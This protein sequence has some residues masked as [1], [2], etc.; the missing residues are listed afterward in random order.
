MNK[1]D[2]SNEKLTKIYVWTN[3]LFQL[4]LI[5]THTTY[6]LADVG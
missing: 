4:F 6:K 1:A 3:L 5:H 2:P